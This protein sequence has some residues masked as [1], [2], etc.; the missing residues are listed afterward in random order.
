MDFYKMI[1]FTPKIAPNRDLF[2][3]KLTHV[4]GL[5]DK[6]GLRYYDLW[7]DL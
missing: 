6:L 7:E 2:T 1:I 4:I 3:P 5:E